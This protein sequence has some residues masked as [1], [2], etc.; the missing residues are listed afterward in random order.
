[1]KDRSQPMVSQ[2]FPSLSGYDLPQAFEIAAISNLPT[3]L[4]LLGLFSWNVRWNLSRNIIDIL[5]TSRLAPTPI[6]LADLNGYQL[7]LSKGPWLRTTKGFN[8]FNPFNP[9]K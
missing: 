4:I 2:G 5:R 7:P 3:L 9:F 6:P 1:M 8:P